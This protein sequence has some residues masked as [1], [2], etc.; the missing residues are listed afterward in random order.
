MVMQNSFPDDRYPPT[1]ALA[2][3]IKRLPP[4]GPDV[5][6]E[7][8]EINAGPGLGLYRVLFI[9][10]QNRCLTRLAWF[11]GVESGEKLPPIAAEGQ[12]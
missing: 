11:W 12:G 9:V 5:L 6:P 8:I 7:R 4:P 10:R 2:A 1:N 3:A